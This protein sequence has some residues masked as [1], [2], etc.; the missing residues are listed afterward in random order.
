MPPGERSVHELLEEELETL[1]TVSDATEENRIK[2]LAHIAMLS[3]TQPEIN[4]ENVIKALPTLLEL[5]SDSLPGSKLQLNA[6][7]SLS[8]LAVLDEAITEAMLDRGVVDRLKTSVL[9]ACEDKRHGSGLRMNV[10][11]MTSA[12]VQGSSRAGDLLVD[13]GLVQLCLDMIV[14]PLLNNHGVEDHATGADVELVEAACDVLCQMCSTSPALK[15]R[16]WE[17]GGLEAC[18]RGMMWSENNNMDVCVRA[19]MAL[20]MFLGGDSD[21]EKTTRLQRLCNFP[22]AITQLVRLMRQDTDPD[23]A[24]ISRQIFAALASHPALKD[25]A[26]AAMRLNDHQQQAFLH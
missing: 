12:L 8:G 17:L 5:M 1:V 6:M 26:V 20:G 4:R 24:A 22:G 18:A 23:C 7:A 21:E 15:T 10:A 11:V 25:Q 3:S 9:P 16:L 2:N 13:A 14:A 19:L